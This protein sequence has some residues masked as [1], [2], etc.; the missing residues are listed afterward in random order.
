[1]FLE[2]FTRFHLYLVALNRCVVGFVFSIK[3]HHVSVKML[4]EVSIEVVSFISV[5]VISIYPSL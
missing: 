3:F 4:F 2:K 1:V 5:F